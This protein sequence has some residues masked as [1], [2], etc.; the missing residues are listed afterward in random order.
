MV[1]RCDR[2][3]DLFEQFEEK[4]PPSRRQQ[5]RLRRQHGTWNMETCL[6]VLARPERRCYRTVNLDPTA[7]AWAHGFYVLNCQET[8]TRS[9]VRDAVAPF[10]YM[11]SSSQATYEAAALE[12]LGGLPTATTEAA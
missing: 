2:T 4:K 6:E 12:Q 8:H 1:K 9:P 11:G 7:P 5:R 3:L 10:N